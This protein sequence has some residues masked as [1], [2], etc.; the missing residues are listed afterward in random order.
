MRIVSIAP[1]NTEIVC[2]LG[3]G[4]CLVGVDNWSDYPPDVVA[5][6]PRLG[7]DLD[8]D[9]DRVAALQPDLVLCSLSVPGMERCVQRVQERGLPHLIL[10]PDSIPDMMREI[11]AVGEATGRQAEAARLVAG[12]RQRLAAVASAVA[13][14]PRRRL[15]WEWWPRPYI[16]PGGRN[17]LTEV[18]ALAGGENLFARVDARQSRPSAEEIVALDPE[19]ILLAWPGVPMDRLQQQVPKVALRPGW[20]AVAA[21]R[22]GQVT[23]V[24]EGLYCRPSPRLIDGV[25]ELARLIHSEC[26]AR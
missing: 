14:A 5:P 2:A 1:S 22:A 20:D 3:L 4:E 6:L 25:E 15:Y 21:V 13:G 11:G 10:D 17:W 8:I 26:F 18:S 19:F 9:G 23:A 7:P 24:A 16:T 12:L